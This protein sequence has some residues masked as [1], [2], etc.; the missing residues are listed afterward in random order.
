MKKR[1]SLNKAFI[2]GLSLFSMFCIFIHHC[3]IT[4][5]KTQPV[6][7]RTLEHKKLKL[8]RK[9]RRASCKHK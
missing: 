8:N 2:I 1:L 4:L 6:I 5:Q 7:Y 3:K 9:Q